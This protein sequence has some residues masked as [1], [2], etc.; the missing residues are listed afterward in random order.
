MTETI[1][2]KS[3][4]SAPDKSGDVRH[5]WSK[6]NPEEVQI[7]KEMFE[8]YVKGEKKYGAYKTGK[9]GEPGEMIREFDPD[10]ES[11]ILR[12]QVVGG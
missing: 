11:I 1:E 9:N 4:I 10:A 2:R 7:A 5:E 8:K 6:D 3:V 12:A